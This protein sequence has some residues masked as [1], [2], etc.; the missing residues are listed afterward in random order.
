MKAK[1]KV[2]EEHMSDE[3]KCYLITTINEPIT[4][5]EEASLT[6]SD[7]VKYTQSSPSQFWSSQNTKKL[8]QNML[9]NSGWEKSPK[10]FFP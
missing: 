8:Q 6:T 7:H 3:M 10:D 5:K 4:E 1:K 2:D 9:R